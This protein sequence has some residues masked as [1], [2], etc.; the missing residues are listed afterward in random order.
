[1]PAS[2]LLSYQLNVKRVIKRAFTLAVADGVA[3]LDGNRVFAAKD[4][5]VGLFPTP[6][7]T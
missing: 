4:L 1:M 2:R 7:E 3:L 5:R 6:L